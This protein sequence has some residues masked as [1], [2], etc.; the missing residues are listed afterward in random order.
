[1]AATRAGP[2]A[3]V[4]TQ[5]PRSRRHRVD[6]TGHHRRGGKAVLAIA[7]P[8][9]GEILRNAL[10]R[11][12]GRV[13]ITPSDLPPSATES[14]PTAFV[15]TPLMKMRC[16]TSASAGSQIATQYPPTIGGAPAH[17]ELLP[18]TLA[19]DRRSQSRVRG[20]AGSARHRFREE[21]RRPRTLAEIARYLSLRN[22]YEARYSPSLVWHW[23]LPP[24][25]EDRRRCRT[26]V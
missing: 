9:F 10:R 5:R 15:S 12:N 20:C 18:E 25:Q 8:R 1:M 19:A 11:G 21:L 3:S 6:A 2:A 17:P 24:R 22:S 26:L 13:T 16:G 4:R 7:R 14:R 23:R